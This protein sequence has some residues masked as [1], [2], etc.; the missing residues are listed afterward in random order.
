MRHRGD[1]I[2][3]LHYHYTKLHPKHSTLH[4]SLEKFR[5]FVKKYG[6]FIRATRD[7]DMCGYC[8]NYRTLRKQLNGFKQLYKDHMNDTAPLFEVTT[9]KNNKIVAACNMATIFLNQTLSNNI[10]SLMNNCDVS[11]LKLAN[12]FM[13]NSVT[14]IREYPFKFM[15]VCSQCHVSVD[16]I[17]DCNESTIFERQI[18]TVYEP[19]HPDRLGLFEIKYDST[20]QTK[21]YSYRL[22]SYR[23]RYAH[24]VDIH[25]QHVIPPISNTYK[26]VSQLEVESVERYPL[27][28][29]ESFLSKSTIFDTTSKNKWI[30]NLKE[31]KL[32]CEH[33]LWS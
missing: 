17:C 5:Q 31:Y 26:H 7:S 32:L 3:H 23:K 12:K 25:D 6:I 4:C 13:N 20:K 8:S 10:T 27:D 15:R 21:S 2:S 30:K 1:Y 19:Q 11:S 28:A 16:E 24:F 14:Y 18:D 22:G 9:N 33:K 29:F